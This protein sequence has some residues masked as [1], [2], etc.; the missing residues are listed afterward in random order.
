MRCVIS[1][2]DTF[3]NSRGFDN[4]TVDPSQVFS[5]QR[6]MTGAIS[7]REEMQVR[8]TEAVIFLLILQQFAYDTHTPINFNH[9]S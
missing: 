1:I 5:D 9:M 3:R 2:L 6:P 8:H 7:H 4:A